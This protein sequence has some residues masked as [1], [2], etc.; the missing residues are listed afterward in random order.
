MK[1]L[2]QNTTMSNSKYDALVLCGPSG[3]GK[4]TLLQRLFREFPNAF[5]YSVSH[6]TRTPRGGE[7]DGVHYHFST[8]S[9]MEKLILAD[10]ML[11]YAKFSNNI[12]GTSK[13]SVEAVRDSGKI[14]VLD[15]EVQGVKQ[16]KESNLAPLYIFVKPPSLDK[17]EERL[18]R[19]GT[20]TEESLK[21]RLGAA[22]QEIE[23]GETPN[24]FHLVLLNDSIDGAYTQL[25]SF[26][27]ERFEIK[28]NGEAGD[29][30]F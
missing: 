19:R 7:V 25:S 13:Q 10:D 4:T 27:V 18:R 11:E 6:T 24:N 30:A 29:D 17:L 3:V 23:Y 22:L 20:E 8:P 26:V 2:F 14:C 1:I 15:I 21:W 28:D 12:Y 5:G 16:I 9:Q